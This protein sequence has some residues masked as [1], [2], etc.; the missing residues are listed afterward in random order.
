MTGEHIGEATIAFVETSLKGVEQPV[1]TLK[2]NDIIVSSHASGGSGGE[3]RLTEAVSLNF[4]KLQLPD[5]QLFPYHRRA[6]GQPQH[7]L[8]HHHEHRRHRY[9]HQH[10]PHHHRHLESDDSRGHAVH[11]LVHPR[12]QP[13]PRTGSLTLS[14]STTN[15]L[16]VPLAGIAFGGSGS[17]RN[18]TITPTANASGSATVTITVTDSGGLSANRSF[19]VTVSPV[20]DP[21]VIQA[22]AN[23]VTGQDIPLAVNSERQRHRHRRRQRERHSGFGKSRPD[24]R[25]KHH[26]Q[27]QRQPPPR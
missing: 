11:H 2:L 17:S 25:R 10:L 3:D 15:P 8:G 13:K 6:D 21:P 24:S 18:V 20:N 14:R 4:A 5:L 27:R 19:T 22:V 1:L 9:W 7:E 12:R 23:Q 26:L 16:V